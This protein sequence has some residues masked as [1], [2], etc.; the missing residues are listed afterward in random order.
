M[1]PDD[2]IIKARV[3][4]TLEAQS[5][6][7]WTIRKED[8]RK[9]IPI[10]RKWVGFDTMTLLYHFT[11]ATM[12]TTYG[13]VVMEDSSRELRRH[14]PIWLNAHGRVLITGLG[15]G[16]VVRGLLA[17][18]RVEHI[19]V[20]EIDAKILQIVGKEFESD[21]RVRLIHGTPCRFISPILSISR[22]TIFGRT[23]TRL[24]RFCTPD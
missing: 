3:P 20:V 17:S 8:V 16:C 24:F 1:K 10:F 4:E 23:A 11:D 2:Y 19:T 9:V 12:Q 22:G 5:F 13:E 7:L 14:L 18:P 15:L 6:G 21:P